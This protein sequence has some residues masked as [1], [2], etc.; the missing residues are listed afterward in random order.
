MYFLKKISVFSVADECESAHRQSW[1]SSAPRLYST[2]DTV[3][4]IKLLS[5]MCI[6]I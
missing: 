2:K 3:A 6:Q 1:P 5:F 4:N